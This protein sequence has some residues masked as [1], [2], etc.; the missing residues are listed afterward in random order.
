VARKDRRFTGEDVRR[1]YCKNLGATQRRLFDIT[2][3]DWSDYDSIEKFR[4]IFKAL[5]DSGLLDD[6][7]YL[8]P[9][10]NYL[11]LAF[12]VIA[13]LIESDSAVPLGIDWFPVVDI[14]KLIEQAKKE[15]DAELESLLG[16]E[17]DG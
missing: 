15:R 6:L 9:C 3:C 5:R 12:D 4:I 7:I 16:I 1:I 17:I 2:T 14:E 13:N 8:M 10:G 11:R